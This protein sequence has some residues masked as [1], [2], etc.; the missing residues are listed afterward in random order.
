MLPQ[1]SVLKRKMGIKEKEEN[2]EFL[3]LKLVIPGAAQA[4]AGSEG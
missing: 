1:T 3:K 2:S 4:A